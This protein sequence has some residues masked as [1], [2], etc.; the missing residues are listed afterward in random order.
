MKTLIAILFVCCGQFVCG[1]D[2][3]QKPLH[4]RIKEAIDSKSAI[5]FKSEDG[6]R[7]VSFRDG[8]LEGGGAVEPIFLQISKVI[9]RINYPNSREV[10]LKEAEAIY[11]KYSEAVEKA[12]EKPKLE[13]W[14]SKHSDDKLLTAVIEGLCPVGENTV[15]IRYFESYPRRID[16]IFIH[17]PVPPK[18][19]INPAQQGVAPQSATRS[20]SKSEGD[21]EPQPESEE[22]SR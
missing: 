3:G 12:G 1:D 15:W 4:A 19:Q 10:T 5:I 13:L 14:I 21:D 18:N 6:L 11:S 22:R 7:T 8:D 16:P 2:A 17:K 9:W 20:E